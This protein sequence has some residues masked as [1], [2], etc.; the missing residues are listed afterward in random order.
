MNLK[1]RGLSMKVVL[2]MFV[3]CFGVGLAQASD[4]A[5]SEL[6]KRVD[7]LHQAR[8]ADDQET[9]YSLLWSG[10]RDEISYEHFLREWQF[11]VIN[12]YDIKNINN[13]ADGQADV[14][15]S[16]ALDMGGFAFDGVDHQ[17]EWV[18][19]DGQWYM[20]FSP[21]LATPFDG[22]EIIEIG[23]D[24]LDPIQPEAP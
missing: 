21:V 16:F 13:L 15:V 6:R 3:F 18:L 23:E 1:A 9:I 8:M 19:E 17:Q 11:S 7:A 2:V 24:D 10:F 5:E 12:A 14:A 20:K 22:I 4:V